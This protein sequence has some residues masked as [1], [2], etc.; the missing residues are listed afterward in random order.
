M[1]VQE[2]EKISQTRALKRHVIPI[3]KKT[4]KQTEVALKRHVIPIVKKTRRR[5]ARLISYAIQNVKKTRKQTEVALKRHVIPIVKKAREHTARLISYAIQNVN[6][7]VRRL[8][9]R[10]HDTADADLLT[11]FDSKST[12]ISSRYRKAVED[13]ARWRYVGRGTNNVVWL[14]H[15]HKEQIVVRYHY[16]Q[17]D[18]MIGIYKQKDYDEGRVE[19]RMNVELGNSGV[20]P[21]IRDVYFSNKY[22]SLQQRKNHQQRL[23]SRA[24]HSAS[25][26]RSPGSKQ[27]NKETVQYVSGQYVRYGKLSRMCKRPHVIMDAYDCDLEDYVYAHTISREMCSTIS[28]A[29]VG[30][31]WK[32]CVEHGILNADIKLNNVVIRNRDTNSADVKLIDFDPNFTTKY[33]SHAAKDMRLV[34]LFSEMSTEMEKHSTISG[35]MHPDTCKIIMHLV[36]CTMMLNSINSRQSSRDTRIMHEYMKCIILG[37]TSDSPLYTSHY[38]AINVALSDMWN[39]KATAAAS[40]HPACCIR[41]IALFFA[42]DTLLDDHVQCAFLMHHYA[43]GAVSYGIDDVPKR[44]P[45]RVVLSM[46]AENVG[47]VLHSCY[48]DSANIPSILSCNN[49]RRRYSLS[50]RNMSANI[51]MYEIIK[52]FPIDAGRFK[53]TR[54]KSYGGRMNCMDC[55]NI[56]TEYETRLSERGKNKKN[57]NV[58]AH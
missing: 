30:L 47:A 5:R 55:M 28:V 25:K 54:S 1:H 18:E 13:K 19:F 24:G 23:S 38:Q 4:R 50:K 45:G 56:F 35:P 8:E 29:L 34:K 7:T 31:L 9:A 46:H 33:H 3:V 12:H 42:F 15:H 27:V 58:F 48:T 17:E 11:K 37:E 6:R 20:S 16:P 2:L 14:L 43:A 26:N 51:N 10:S 52:P 53:S 40:E 57:N 49:K 36:C 39:V 44:L 21:E 22:V 32:A 41:T